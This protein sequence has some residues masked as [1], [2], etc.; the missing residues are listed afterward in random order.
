MFERYQKLS[1]IDKEHFKDVINTLL[2][3][4]YIFKYEY[5]ENGSYCQSDDFYFIKRNRDVI[6]EYLDVIGY[7]IDI[8]ESYGICYISTFPSS[9]RVRF[10][11][12]STLIVYTLRHL[13]EERRSDS[14]SSF[15]I[16][17]IGNLIS[18]YMDLSEEGRKPSNKE[19]ASALRAVRDAHLIKKNKGDWDKDD[20]EIMIL[21]SILLVLSND[22]I[23]SLEDEYIGEEE[24]VII[25]DE[26]EEDLA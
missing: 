18:T 14:T 24:E 19:I 13:Y 10:D 11:K 21:P 1:D 26:D 6:N 20:T 4:T 8:D 23:L 15:V 9:A 25:N 5:K 12:L 3:H 7:A 2:E 16:I 17:T 22:K